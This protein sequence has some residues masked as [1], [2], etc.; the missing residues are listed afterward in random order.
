MKITKLSDRLFLR[1]VETGIFLTEKEAS[2]I[3]HGPVTL[4]LESTKKGAD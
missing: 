1:R 4:I 2:L 3:N